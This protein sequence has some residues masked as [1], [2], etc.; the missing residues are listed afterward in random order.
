MHVCKHAL[1]LTTDIT[2][3]IHYLKNSSYNVCMHT[4]KLTVFFNFII[5]NLYM[6]SMVVKVSVCVCI[7]TEI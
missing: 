1:E 5:L 4:Q 7:Y 3:Y 6:F 2:R